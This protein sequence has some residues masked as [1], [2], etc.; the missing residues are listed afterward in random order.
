MPPRTLVFT[1]N[2]KKLISVPVPAPIPLPVPQAPKPLSQPAPA[3][4][5]ARSR[6]LIN[7]RPTMMTSMR[8]TMYKPG[9]SCS[10]CG[11]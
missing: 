10:P 4:A 2:K 3:P 6:T 9:G 8:T 7:I 1:S 5:P 11:H